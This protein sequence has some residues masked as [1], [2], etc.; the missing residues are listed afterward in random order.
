LTAEPA[1]RRYQALAQVLDDP[2]VAECARWGNYR[3]DIHQ[4]SVGPYEFYKPY[5]FYR[6]EVKRLLTQY[7]PRRP[8]AI[9]QLFRSRGLYPRLEAP[10]GQLRGGS[11]T[12]SLGEGTVYYTITGADPRLPGGE[13][14]SDAR[15]YSQPISLTPGQRVKVRASA[16]SPSAREWSLLVEF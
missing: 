11:L 7:F 12:L 4:Y 9:V 6:P 2:L 15:P 14:S 10:T 5:I 1:A 16:G 13:V 8:G 3:R